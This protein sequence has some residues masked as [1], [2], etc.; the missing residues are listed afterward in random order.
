MSLVFFLFFVH[1]TNILTLARVSI[2]YNYLILAVGLA[3][4]F[5]WLWKLSRI[6]DDFT[7]WQQQMLLIG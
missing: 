2:A 5:G 1:Q 4:N 6:A 3:W 7:G